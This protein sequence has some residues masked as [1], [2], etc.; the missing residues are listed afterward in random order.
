MAP[1]LSFD[2]FLKAGEPTQ[3]RHRPD[4]QA[5]LLSLQLETRRRTRI[6]RSTSLARREEAPIPGKA[7]ILRAAPLQ[8]LHDESV[9]EQSPSLRKDLPPPRS[10]GEASEHTLPEIMFAK[11]QPWASTMT[12]RP[13]RNPPSARPAPRCYMKPL[14]LAA[15]RM[16]M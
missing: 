1:D 4:I 15:V 7:P 9:Q 5:D 13:S 6:W 12:T 10:L 16:K 3:S 11:H 14:T 8:P 2:T